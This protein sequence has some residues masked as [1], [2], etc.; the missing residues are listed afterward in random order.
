[1]WQSA[2]SKNNLTARVVIACGALQ[3]SF[4][5]NMVGKQ[6]RQEKGCDTASELMIF[7]KI[8]PGKGHILQKATEL[9]PFN[10]EAC[11]LHTL[12]NWLNQLQRKPLTALKENCC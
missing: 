2:A 5:C 11:S 8:V 12:R 1:M 3:G 9:F 4:L 7:N 6:V 10:Q